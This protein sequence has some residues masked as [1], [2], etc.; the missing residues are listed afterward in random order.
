MLLVGNGLLITRDEKNTVIE[1]GCVA[2]D[3]D[4]I[5]ETGTTDTLRR[6]YP[7]ADFIDAGKKI[8]MPGLINTHMHF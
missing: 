3:G 7:D 2:I 4:L 1:N 5:V 6:K 8:I